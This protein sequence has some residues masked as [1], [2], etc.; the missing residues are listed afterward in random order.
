MATLS[1]ATRLSSRT[2]KATQVMHA[3]L[4]LYWGHH[5]LHQLVPK[6]WGQLERVKNAQPR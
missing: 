5:R 2:N 6:D 4:G 3:R 1:G